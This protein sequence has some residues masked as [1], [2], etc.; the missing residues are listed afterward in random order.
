[1]RHI[2]NLFLA[3]LAVILIFSSIGGMTA[4]ADDAPPAETPA[5]E[6]PPVEATPPP[7]TESAPA[8]EETPAP[9]IAA[10][11]EELPAE[12]GL[13]ILDEAG[14]A[15]PLVSEQ[16][17][18]IAS[19]GDPRFFDSLNNKW[20]GYTTTTCPAP[21]LPADC[22]VVASNPI[23]EAVSAFA[24]NN[25]SGAIYVEAGTYT[26]TVTVNATP[27]LTGI[28]GD[29]SATTILNGHFGLILNNSFT[30]QGFTVSEGV[31]VVEPSLGA[32]TGDLL[33]LSDL[34][35]TNSAGSGIY[36][37]M[38]GDVAFEDIHADG[39]QSYGM[40]I[41]SAQNINGG[42][43]NT[44]NHNDSAGLYASA[45]NDVQLYNVTAS[46]NSLYG[47]LVPAVSGD[48][49]LANITAS[50][51]GDDGLVA[52]ASG[53]LYLLGNNLFQ[54]NRYNGASIYSNRSIYAYSESIT[55]SGNGCGECF[56]GYG[57]YLLSREDIHLTG[58]NLFY[59]NDLDGLSMV[60]DESFG[61][62][63]AENI[64][65]YGNGVGIGGVGK[66]V[67][68][69]APDDITISG[70]NV[71][72]DNASA[73]A[74][75]YAYGNVILENV[76][77]YNNGEDGAYI[78]N[79]VN[80]TVNC[81][82]FHDNGVFG[83][84][85]TLG[86]RLTLNSVTFSGNGAGDLS[87]SGGGLIEGTADCGG[88]GGGNDT[89]AFKPWQVFQSTGDDVQTDC[90]IFAGAILIL[91]NGDRAAF[92]CEISGAIHANSIQSGDLP[93]ALPS[94]AFISGMNTG[95]GANGAPMPVNS[96]HVVSFVL[97][98]D[99]GE[100]AILFWDGSQWQKLGST[101]NGGGSLEASANFTGVFILVK[102]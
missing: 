35:V 13:L 95:A 82:N 84:N 55:A 70:V 59:G 85:V 10:V 45:Y 11:L 67:Y 21:V 15:V 9:E 19:G 39:A 37:S 54:D 90:G 14:D 87:Q 61:N 32:M 98:Q 78:F 96:L 50:N 51:N 33:T 83:L 76:T 30:L 66:G 92:F 31:T 62:V 41:E 63:Y 6:L 36:I 2:K 26:E 100:Y 69:Y 24:A 47:I 23:S 7:T 12:S 101:N 56:G 99:E 38:T 94:G 71:F 75:V 8:V 22:H 60:V 72:Y 93:G 48:V 64:T 102:K 57:L 44:F 16:A 81:G 88:G 80:V 1:M 58:T 5:P 18:E 77:S 46:N 34:V 28:I 49:E 53:N 29:G 20:I 43:E 40:F 3:F 4:L 65:S 74:A 73:G 86:S 27:N 68:V 91:P 89:P 25:G 17:A 42:G 97:P 79:P 52:S